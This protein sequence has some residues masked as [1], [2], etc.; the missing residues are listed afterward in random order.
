MVIFLHLD[1]VLHWTRCVWMRGIQFPGYRQ[2]VALIEDG[3]TCCESIPWRRHAP[4]W[5]PRLQELVKIKLIYHET[6]I[7][8][9]LF[10]PPW[11]EYGYNKI[12]SR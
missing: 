11:M 5:K 4:G 8:M 6:F 3:I 10:P 12:K 9:Y 1:P 2:A 7:D